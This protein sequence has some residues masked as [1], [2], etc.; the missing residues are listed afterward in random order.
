MSLSC[1]LFSGFTEEEATPVPA[2]TSTPLP[3]I[4]VAPGEVNP[5]EPVF[6]TGDIPYTSPFFLNTISQPFILLEDQ[7]GFVNRDKNFVF[8]LQGQTIGP[9]TIDDADRLTYSLSL[10]SI[11]Q[12]TQVDVDHDG[13]TDPGI[14]VYALSYW[15]N[16]WGDPFLEERDGGGWS[17]A[18]IPLC[19]PTQNGKMRSSVES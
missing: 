9:V 5:Q 17:T 12:G 8:P 18:Y 11:P 13:E 4:P 1:Q 10:P 15:S 19:A 2:A 3:L 14:Q 16:T 7:A 6:V